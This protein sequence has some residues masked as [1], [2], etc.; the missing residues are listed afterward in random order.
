MRSPRCTEWVSSWMAESGVLSLVQ[1]SVKI[2][3]QHSLIS[4][5]VVVLALSSSIL[6]SREQTLASSRLGSGGRVALA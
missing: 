3:A 6:F 4:R 5:C 1:V 2:T